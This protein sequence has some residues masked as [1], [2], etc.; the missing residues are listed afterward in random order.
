MNNSIAELE[1]NLNPEVTSVNFVLHI[2]EIAAESNLIASR[3]RKLA[4]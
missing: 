2:F 3:R 1:D 4:S